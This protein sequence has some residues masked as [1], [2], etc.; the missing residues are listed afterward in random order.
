L[1]PMIDGEIIE[2]LGFAEVHVK[3]TKSAAFMLRDGDLKLIYHV[4]APS[5]L[6]D[7]GRDPLEM[8]DLGLCKEHQATREAMEKTL[9]SIVDPEAV[10]A[11]AKSDQLGHTLKYGGEAIIRNTQNIVASP[12]PV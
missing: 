10:D 3:S 8:N 7:L 11:H 1:W 2:R 5:Q 12:P 9:R 6:F 4:D